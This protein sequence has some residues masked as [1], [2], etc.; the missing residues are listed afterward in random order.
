[1]IIAH[2]KSPH[3]SDILTVYAYRF[4]LDTALSATLSFFA[5]FGGGLYASLREAAPFLLIQQLG[6][7]ARRRPFTA[8]GAVGCR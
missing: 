6:A 3:L 8:A 2:E 5:A 7:N 4:I 1:L